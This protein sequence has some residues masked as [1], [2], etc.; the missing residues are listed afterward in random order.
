MHIYI[1]LFD[2]VRSLVIAMS[3]QV[4]QG[5]VYNLPLQVM[6]E[7]VCHLHRYRDAVLP[8]MVHDSECCGLDYRCAQG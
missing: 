3:I 5:Y 4:L 2:W 1:A 7:D 8:P 6:E